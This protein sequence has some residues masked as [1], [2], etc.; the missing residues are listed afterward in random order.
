MDIENEAALL[1][2]LEDLRARLGAAKEREASDR[3]QRAH[4]AEERLA[5]AKKAVAD[6]RERLANVENGLRDLR[7]RKDRGEYLNP[8][9]FSI[10]TGAR[11]T[12]AQLR[13][14]LAP[15]ERELTEARDAFEG[16][17]EAFR[18][19]ARTLGSVRLNAELRGV[20][21][22]IARLRINT[23]EKEEPA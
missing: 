6:L 22:R 13:S 1:A 16:L 18:G 12:I 4:A 10:M 23:M 19:E 7:V 20:A 5:A 3:R 15:L 8:S 21:L 17:E 2:S 11:G 9:D 14:R